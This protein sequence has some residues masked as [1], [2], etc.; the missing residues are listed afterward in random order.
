MSGLK[1]LAEGKKRIT[2]LT[3]EPANPDSPTKTELDAGIYAS[4]KVLNSD[5][6]WT[7]T[8]SEAVGEPSVEDKNNAEALGRGNYNL[9]LTA[10]RYWDSATKVADATDDALFAAVKTKG[11]SLW[12]YV[13][14][15]AKDATEAWAASDEIYL[16]G[17]VITDEPQV[18][19]ATGF[20]KRRVP[21][22]AQSMFT[23]ITVAAG[24]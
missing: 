7:A 1:S 22:K 13:R 23:G 2:I 9:G 24:A 19:D 18:V 14:E 4:P 11:T 6:N 17:H 16:G 20:I 3:T 12:I 15:T 21:L 10:F 8:D 5:F